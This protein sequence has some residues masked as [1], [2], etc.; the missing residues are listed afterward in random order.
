MPK[1]ILIIAHR[2]VTYS[3]FPE[4]SLPGFQAVIDENYDGVELDVRL[5]RDKELVVFHDIRLE[6][7]TRDGH[8]MVRSKKFSEL[9]KLRLK[10]ASVDTC[11]ASL[12][13][14]LELFK[15]AN[16]LIN[17]E[18]KSEMPLRGK[19]EQRVID[20]IH[21]FGVHNN[22]ILSSFN[23]LVIRKVQKIDPDIRTGFIYQKRLPKFNQ[24]LAKGLIATSWHP[25]Y[26]GVS[27]LLLEKAADAGCA[28][29]PWT[30]NEEKDFRRMM[31]LEVDGVITDF[32]NRARN[33]FES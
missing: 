21:T 7:L 9:K 28:V 1:K 33:I 5:T 32:P 24:K 14:V 22:V 19:I 11:I 16:K 15:P 6:R 25:N 27:A 10:N 4:N 17:I 23:P 12:A 30:V 8:G 3:G 20:L 29:F 31:E 26:L 18:I 2:G 13:E